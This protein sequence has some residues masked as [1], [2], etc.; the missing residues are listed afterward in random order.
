MDR[1]D[2]LPSTDQN[3]VEF[4]VSSMRSEVFDGAQGSENN[5]EQL[6]ARAVEQASSREIGSATLVGPE[7]SRIESSQSAIDVR[8]TNEAG[9]RQVEEYGYIARASKNIIYARQNAL[10]RG[11][12]TLAA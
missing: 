4:P 6:S 7:P 3:I 10:T 11:D 9:E 2:M 8:G 12:F 1:R 5:I